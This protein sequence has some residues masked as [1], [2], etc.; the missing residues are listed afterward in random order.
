MKA[1]GNLATDAASTVT[2]AVCPAC[3]GTELDCFFEISELP[4][5]CIALRKTRAAALA[6]AKGGIQLGFC[7]QCGAVNNLQFDSARLTYDS[8]YD[9]SLHFS[10]SFQ[11]YADDAAHY[12]VDRYDLRGKTVLDVGCGNA[13]FLSLVCG[14]GMNRGVGFD[15]TFIPGRANL[16]A[17]QGVQIIQD[18]F[19]DEYAGYTADFLVCRHVLEHISD[20][21]AFLRSIRRAVVGNS[22]GSVFFEVP[23]ATFV[24]QNEGMWDIIYEHCFYY[25]SG[26][27]ARLF[28]SCG[29][30]V[31]NV[32][33]RFHGQYLCLEARA[34]SAKIGELGDAGGDLNSMRDEILKFAELYRSHRAYW[35]EVLRR[36][37]KEEKRVALWGAGAKG[38]MFLNAFADASSLEYIVDVNPHKHGL[39]IPGTGQEVVSPEFLKEYQP[40]VLLIVNPN[41]RDEISCQVSQMGVNADLLSF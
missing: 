34:S 19:S 8:S 2:Q 31:L 35:G 40:D 37:A 38:A 26:A 13:E 12:L 17:G 10:P 1:Q 3:G 7:R 18:Y 4:V 39:Y 24:F 15:P 9:N 28:S 27:M 21:R 22:L 25:S 11:K 32:S 14:L 23:N 36:F 41:Y 20:P 6:C 29:F 33:E 5:N 30:D 16:E